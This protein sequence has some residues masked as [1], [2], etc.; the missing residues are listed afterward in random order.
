MMVVSMV[1]ININVIVNVNL[2]CN[3][4]PKSN[5]IYES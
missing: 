4:I 3:G 5:I 1:V 2:N